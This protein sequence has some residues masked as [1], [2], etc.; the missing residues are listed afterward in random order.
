VLLVV[1]LATAAWTVSGASAAQ[2]AE[3]GWTWNSATH[4]AGSG[5]MAGGSLGG[6]F[7][8]GGMYYIPTVG[9]MV[10]LGEWKTERGTGTGSF[11]YGSHRASYFGADLGMI[12]TGT[13]PLPPYLRVS[14]EWQKAVIMSVAHPGEIT[15]GQYTCHSGV[16]TLTSAAGGYRCGTA[17][18]CGADSM[19][20]SI[21]N[22]AGIAQGGDSGG[23]VWQYTSGGVKLLGWITGGGSP[24]SAAAY[25]N[26]TSAYYTPV[27]ALQDHVWEPSEAWAGN[28]GVSAF[29]SGALADGCFVTASGCVRS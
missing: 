28:A 12:A 19:I 16:S 26:Y 23:P 3:S 15:G 25:P 10:G 20:C 18:E 9:H 14:D 1:A 7:R 2:A 13:K 17:N 22:P 11:G 24:L 8:A 6:V 5:N 29:P 21:T 27:W 4:P